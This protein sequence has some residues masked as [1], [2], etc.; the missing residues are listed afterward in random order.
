VPEPSSDNFDAIVGLC[1][2]T[3]VVGLLGLFF[4]GVLEEPLPVSNSLERYATATVPPFVPGQ[5]H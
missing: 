2:F 1:V 4:A 3:A 5:P